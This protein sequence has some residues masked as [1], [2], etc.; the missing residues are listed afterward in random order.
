MTRMEKNVRFD[1]DGALEKTLAELVPR[2]AP[3][4]L[5]G[6]ILASADE[7]KERVV[8]TPRM[9]SVAAAC[10][11]LIAAVLVGDAIISRSQMDDIFALVGRPSAPAQDLSSVL[12]ELGAAGVGMEV[13][14]GEQSFLTRRFLARMGPD[15]DSGVSIPEISKKLE[16]W[17]DDEGT[18]NPY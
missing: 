12:A 3:P 18:E 8:M 15:P 17:N 10:L 7:V 4:G 6:R 9:W 2:P 11:V 1:E 14:A 16:G 5:K 13:R